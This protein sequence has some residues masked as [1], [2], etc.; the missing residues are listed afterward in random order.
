M[1]EVPRWSRI[2]GVCGLLGGLSYAAAAFAPLPP[3]AE[4]AAAFAFGPL[5]AVA[6]IGLHHALAGER[7]SPL[8]QIAA[9]LTAAGGVT[10]LAM[11]ATQLSIAEF[12]AR[13]SARLGPA[14][15]PMLAAVKAIANAV[16]LGLDV[17]WD[18]LVSA[19]V[20]LFGIAMLRHPAFGRVLGSAGIVLGALLLGF[21]LRH[22]PVP[23]ANADSIDWGPFVA[24]WMM[25]VFVRLL[26][27]PPAPASAED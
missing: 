13:E 2:G 9:F 16:H 15:A 10:V 19:G 12:V 22:F 27:L 26:T 8:T 17:A 1:S 4:R 23:P 3:I 6:A 7:R 5:L 25:V 14:D 24:L 20:V 18:V 11:L 21:N